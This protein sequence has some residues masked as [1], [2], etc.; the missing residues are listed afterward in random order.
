M[1]PKLRMI[2]AKLATLPGA[3]KKIELRLEARAQ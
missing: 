2:K 3:P 1:R